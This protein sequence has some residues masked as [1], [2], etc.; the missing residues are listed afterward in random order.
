M[1][2]FQRLPMEVALFLRK[3]HR[4]VEDKRKKKNREMCRKFKK[5][6]RKAYEQSDYS[7]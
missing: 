7:Y 1:K 2:N 6:W 5:V 3:A 4:V